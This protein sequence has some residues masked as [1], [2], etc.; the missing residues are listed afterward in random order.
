MKKILPA[1]LVSLASATALAAPGD[2]TA[3]LYFST[4]NPTLTPQEKAAIEISQRWQKASATGIKPVDSGD[5]YVRFIFGAQQPSIVCAVLQVCDVALQAGEQVNSINLGDT[6]RWAVEPAITGFGATEVQHLIIKPMDVGLETSLVVTT[7]R[8]TYHFKL[9]SHR[10]QYMPQVAFTYPEEALAKWEAIKR[11]ETVERQK[12][13]IPETGEYLGNLSFNYSISGSTSWKPV[14]VYND[15]VKTIIEMPKTMTQTEAPT[16][17]VV[18][19]DGGWFKD[20]ETVMVN[21]RVQSNRFI[22]DTIFDKAILIAGVGKSQDR[23][24]IQRGE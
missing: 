10:T 19:K 11:H 21:Y 3:D 23:V 8:R 7:N 16:L 18:R 4:N 15:G 20:D 17:L 22:V 6:A 9:R 2:N 14:R 24:T 1:I 13:T 12:A 5:G